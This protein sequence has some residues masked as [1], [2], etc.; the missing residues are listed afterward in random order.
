MLK[1]QRNSKFL[2]NLEPSHLSKHFFM[3]L[4]KYLKTS[5]SYFLSPAGPYSTGRRK[6]PTRSRHRIR[7]LRYPQEARSS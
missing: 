3:R 1:Q 5:L 6:Q 4:I 2:I 7:R